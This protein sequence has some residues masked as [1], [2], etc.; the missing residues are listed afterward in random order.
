MGVERGVARGFVGVLLEFCW[1]TIAPERGRKCRLFARFR[2]LFS[3]ITSMHRLFLRSFAFFAPALG[4][5]HSSPRSV[6]APS[7]RSLRLNFCFSSPFLYLGG[8][9][10][11]A[12]VFGYKK[13][14]T[15]VQNVSL[16]ILSVLSPS[17]DGQNRC[18]NGQNG[19][20]WHNTSLFLTQSPIPPQSRE[21][22]WKC[23]CLFRTILSLRSPFLFKIKNGHLPKPVLIATS[24][25][26]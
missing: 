8:R 21:R 19:V 22:S 2:L 12:G 7:A 11:R 10:R 26:F 6:P 3:V 14:E 25:R 16:F 1:S 15:L 17:P 9:E 5:L 24:K 20:K 4:S 18:Q 23:L 13:R